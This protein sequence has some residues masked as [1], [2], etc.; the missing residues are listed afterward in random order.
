MSAVNDG[1]GA[2]PSGV[3]QDGYHPGQEPWQRGLSVRDYFAAKALQAYIESGGA[4]VVPEKREDAA[5]RAYQYADAM[6]RERNR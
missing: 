1:G 5:R 6:M 2:F 4:S 3:M